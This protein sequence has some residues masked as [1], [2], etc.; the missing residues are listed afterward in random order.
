MIIRRDIKP[1]NLLSDDPKRRLAEV[2]ALL[3]AGLISEEQ[4]RKLLETP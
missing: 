3:K 2:T 1:V 4:M